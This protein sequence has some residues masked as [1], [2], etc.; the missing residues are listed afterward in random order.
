MNITFGG[1]F[2][3]N[4]GLCVIGRGILEQ[5]NKDHKINIDAPK[6]SGYWESFYD[7]FNPE[8]ED[9]YLL[10]GHVPQIPRIAK[11]HDKIVVIV[12][13]E[14]DLPYDWI[15]ALKNPAVKEI[16]TISQFCKTIISRSWTGLPIKVIDMGIDD[17]FKVQGQ[18][19]FK[20]DKSFKFLHISAPHCK[21]KT[22][23]KGLDV[24]LPAFKQAFGDSDKVKL[25]LKLNLIYAN[26]FIQNF[27]QNQ[28]LLSLLPKDTD[29][30][31]IVVTTDYMTV[32]R[33]ND[34][35]SSVDCGVFPSR[36]E[37][38][39]IPQLEIISKGIPVITS[40]YGA[41]TEY[42]VESLR[43]IIDSFIQLNQRFPYFSSKFANPSIADLK[44]KLINVYNNV[45]LYQDETKLIQSKVRSKY[46]WSKCR[47]QMNKYL[48]K[49]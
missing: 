35:Y 43:V 41:T 5:L 23:R 38:L 25:I 4:E 28:Y 42:S 15:E 34:L 6:I 29:I 2:I 40:D 33:L 14:T 24:L 10:N 37:G 22:D 17:R 18:D 46:C 36:A 21:S 1:G 19:L 31:N 32:E 48:K 16:W 49:I 27:D 26:K 39:G 12:V 30:S 13:F 3:G 9:I 47:T 20:K 44:N 7:N 11:N 45:K 8:N